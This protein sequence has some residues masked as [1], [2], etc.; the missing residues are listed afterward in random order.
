[1][2]GDEILTAA[3]VAGMT[4]LPVGTLRY[5]RHLNVHAKPGN[6]I[7]PRSFKLGPRRVA[8]MRSDVESWIAQQY[9]AKSA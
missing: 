7:G 4:K 5:W 8:Y 1:M 2:S 6:H 3:D 9:Q